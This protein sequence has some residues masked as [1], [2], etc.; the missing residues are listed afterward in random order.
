VG[1]E[2]TIK[3]GKTVGFKPA[4]TFKKLIDSNSH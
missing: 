3:T 1:E 2:I 4:P